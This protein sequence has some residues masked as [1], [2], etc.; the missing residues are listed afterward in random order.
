M[1]D[2]DHSLLR[3][4][5]RGDREALEALAR[6]YS[7]PVFRYLVRLS[8]NVTL[9]E[10]LSQ[11]VAV[12]LWRALPGRRFPNQRALNAWVYRVA[13]NAFRMHCRRKSSG[14]VAWDEEPD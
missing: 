3:G 4:I 1:P 11:E 2:P 14:E 7:A 12:Q 9:A 8:G 10:D 5:E 13:A 6:H